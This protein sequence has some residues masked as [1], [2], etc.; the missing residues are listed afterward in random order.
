ML[1]LLW[2][3]KI[4]Y[5][6]WRNVARVIFQVEHGRGV[7]C[8]GRGEGGGGGGHVPLGPLEP[9]VVVDRSDCLIQQSILTDG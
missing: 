4:A 2:I 8:G 6:Q 5:I 7:D 9:I 1:T 3:I